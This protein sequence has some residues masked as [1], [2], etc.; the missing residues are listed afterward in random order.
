M[1]KNNVTKI[2]KS[3]VKV[4]EKIGLKDGIIE[5][6][7]INENKPLV[8]YAFL[9][10]IEYISSSGQEN[11]KDLP[12]SLII[13]KGKFFFHDEGYE[14][15]KEGLYRFVYPGIENQ[16]RI[17]YEA[18]L[19]ALLS[20]IAWVYAHGNSDDEREFSHIMKKALQSKIFATCGSISNWTCN[21]L[22]TKSIKSR[23]VASLTLDD[24]NSYN[25][26]HIMIEVFREDLKKWVV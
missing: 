8:Y 6:L 7:S 3:V 24:W 22:K 18:D 26:G 14:L 11:S 5:P 16:Q 15:K 2:K 9:N 23:V 10:N 13:P 19:D 21:L 17:V 20:G 4:L 1:T 25:N 12:N